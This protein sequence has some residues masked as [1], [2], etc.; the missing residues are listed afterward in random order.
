M[1][2]VLVSLSKI[3]WVGGGV[4][5]QQLSYFRNLSL[6]KDANLGLGLVSMVRMTKI[7]TLQVLSCYGLD[8]AIIS[9]YIY[10]H[11]LIIF[12]LNVAVIILVVQP[13]SVLNSES[14]T[15]VTALRPCIS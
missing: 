5:P 4:E 13:G 6:S 7:V 2:Q 14:P 12:H 10:P 11:H 1:K 8:H 15:L 9:L 3:I